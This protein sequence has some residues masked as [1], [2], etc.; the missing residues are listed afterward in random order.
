MV[1]ANKER[2][3]R[4]LDLLRDGLA[5]KCAATWEGFFGRT[6]WKRSTTG[7]TVQRKART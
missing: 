4:S 2:I 3:S 7:Y 1:M 6:G 5:P